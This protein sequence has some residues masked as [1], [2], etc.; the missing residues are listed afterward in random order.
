M[1]TR[2]CGRFGGMRGGVGIVAVDVDSVEGLDDFAPRDP[3]GDEISGMD[4]I[5]IGRIGVRARGLT[6]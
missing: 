5:G 1:V 3:T 2:G 6:A 4:G